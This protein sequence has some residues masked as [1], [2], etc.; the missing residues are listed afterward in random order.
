MKLIKTSLLIITIGVLLTLSFGINA[1]SIPTVTIDKP[2]SE[3]TIPELQATIAEIMTA[4]QQL[5]ALLLQLT[6]QAGGISGIPS[7]FTFQS[8]LRYGQYSADVKY[9]QI[10]L[11]TD[12]ATKVFQTGAG[13]PG[14]ETMYFGIR[15]KTAVIA[16][17]T[18]YKNDISAITG[19]PISCTGY[20]GPGTRAKINELLADLRSGIAPGEEEEEEEE[21]EE[22]TCGDIDNLCPS[23]CTHQEDSDCTYCGDSIIQSPN[24]EGITE[25]CDTANLN[26]QTCGTRGYAGGTLSC[27]NTCLTFN[28][29][30]CLLGGGGSPSSE[31]GSPAPEPEPEPEPGPVCGDN[32]DNICPSGC[33]HSQDTDCTYCGDNIIQSPNNEGIAEVCDGTDLGE[34]TSCQS[35]FGSG[36]TGSLFCSSGCLTFNTTSCAPLPPPN[37]APV[38]GLI[39]N[40]SVN[41]N[42]ELTFTV[43]ATDPEEDILTYSIQ[44][45]PAG[46]TFQNQTFTWTPSYAQ[47][48]TY[49]LTFIVS[50]SDLTDSEDITITVSNVNRAPV[51]ASIGSKSTNE[52]QELT[53]TVSAT[54]PEEDIL[55]YSI[56]GLVS[57]ITFQD[58]IF[59]WTPTYTQSETYTLTFIVSDTEL[60]DSETITITVADVCAPDTC[61][62]LGYECGS[63]S[64]NCGGTIS[65]GTCESGYTCA[66]GQ[67]IQD[68]P[69]PVCGDGSCN[70]TETCS[71]CPQ[72]C[73]ACPA[74]QTTDQIEQFG[75]TWTFDKEYQYGTFANGDYWVVGDPDVTIIGIDPPSVDDGTGRIKN[76]SQLSSD[77]K[78]FD[79]YSKQ[80]TMTQ[81]F[82]N[83]MTSGA[84]FPYAAAKN[85]AFEVDAGNPLVVPASTSLLSSISNDA[86]MRPQ[87]KAMAILTI[88]ASAPAA[89]SFRPPYAG[90]NKTIEWNKSDINYAPLG[91]V[92]LSGISSPVFPS[93]ATCEAYFERPWPDWKGNPDGGRNLHPSDNMPHYGQDIAQRVG[94]AA[95]MLNSSELNEDKETLMIRFLQ[96]GIDLWGV[97]EANIQFAWVMDG[98]HGPGRKFPILFAG[99]ILNDTNG[100]AAVGTHG[101]TDPVFGEDATTFYLTQA[102]ANR[103]MTGG[104]TWAEGGRY[105]LYDGGQVNT[106]RN[107]EDAYYVPE[108]WNFV[109]PNGQI[110]IPEYIKHGIEG[111]LWSCCQGRWISR[112]YDASYRAEQHGSSM[113]GFILAA[114]I[115]G[116]KDEWNHDALFDYTDRWMNN[117][118][119]NAWGTGLPYW[120]STYTEDWHRYYHADGYANMNA[121]DTYRAQYGCVWNGTSEWDCSECLY[122]CEVTQCAGID[123]F[124]GTWPNCQ[125]CNS[126]DGCIGNSYRDYYC[127]GTSCIYST[128]DCSDCSCSCGG[129]NTTE[130]I[131]NNNCSDG[132]DNDCDGNIDMADSG[133][134]CTPEHTQ[135]CNTGEQGICSSGTQTCQSNGTWGTCV[136]DNQP[137]TENCTDSIDNDCDGTTDCSDTDCSSD[138]VCVT[139]LPQGYVA[140][141]KFE[142]NTNDE[143]GVNNGTIAGNPQYVTGV[144]GQALDFDG[145]GDY[146]EFP[147]EQ[148]TICDGCNFT[149]SSW[150]YVDVFASNNPL[151]FGRSS[152]GINAVTGLAKIGGGIMAIVSN[153]SNFNGD[154][155]P[156]V[157]AQ[158]WTHV[159]ARYNGT[160]IEC[161]KDGI[162][163]GSPSL[164]D[165][166]GVVPSLPA[167]VDYGDE[168]G[169]LYNSSSHTFDGVIDEVMIFDKALS[170]SEIQQIYDA[171]KPGASPARITTT[172]EK[173]N[174]INSILSSIRSAIQDI[175]KKMQPLF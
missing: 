101:L 92:D 146:V 63:H 74:G 120:P 26:N 155:C 99:T 121:W 35:Y 170:E 25:V 67:C 104:D 164:V 153:G 139:I 72:D 46:A 4:I 109:N 172:D 173:L 5:Q 8:N 87:L 50:D 175:L 119:W 174:N 60:T 137:N 100:M 69:A 57:G 3:M 56:Q 14:N 37:E 80:Q 44:G 38:L 136:Q 89:N 75:I 111:P 169:R 61:S 129:Y 18:K 84:H 105:T 122:N 66:S 130:S 118:T 96:Y 24:N 19:Y 171:Q 47:S 115:M 125:N 31:G 49:N 134:G 88:L 23:G 15:T 68:T 94:V 163:S 12:P 1:Q 71:T 127:S 52:N 158:E 128:D 78:D 98:G 138:P 13:S 116:L 114:R 160:Y 10:F 108:D 48:E 91:S 36:W 9:L 110:G 20:L 39:G 117:N 151:I 42:Q 33:A 45:L 124:C 143:T 54:D 161:F 140:Y 150:I 126:L 145:D 28:V 83:N 27:S 40:Q 65:C 77:I 103:Y 135:S 113:P 152:N 86:I 144:Q 95:I 167:S 59:S 112:R 166:E 7:T 132:I 82:D 16:F 141:W 30:A 148:Q 85:V 133:C 123:T 106:H 64:D 53:F 22:A 34:E 2:I 156:T 142:G 159:V 11:N 93:L 58:Q 102:E 73:G 17:Q 76:G 162:G 149:I 41:E 147:A 55:T 21:E 90:D 32:T 107:Y 154:Y 168:I 51:L 97:Y 43:S 81:G 29:S 79:T 157:S 6:G 165:L 62:G 131:A 70:G